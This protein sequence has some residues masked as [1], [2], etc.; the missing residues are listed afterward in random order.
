MSAAVARNLVTVQTLAEANRRAWTKASGVFA[1][2]INRRYTPFDGPQAHFDDAEEFEILYGGAKG[3]GKALC[4]ATPLPTPSGWTTMGQVRPGDRLFDEAGQPCRV[5][6]VTDVMRGHD[7]YRVTFSDGA[8]IIA[9]ADHEWLTWTLAERSA[10]VRRTDEFRAQRRTARPKRG[11]GIREFVA[12]IG[13]TK[14]SPT[15]RVRTTTEIARSLRSGGKLNALNHAAP[16]AGPLSLC[17]ADLPINPYLLGAW[18]GDGDSARG[19]LTIGEAD[20]PEMLPI[21][22]EAGADAVHSAKKTTQFRLAGLT[23]QLRALGVLNDKHIPTSYLRGGVTQRLALLQG[24][25]DTDG[26]VTRDGSIEVTWTKRV[27]V[28]GLAE[29]LASL[30]IKAR[31]RPGRA[32]IAGKDCGP[33]WR[34]HFS[35]ELP[36]AR[37]PRKLNAQRRAGLNRRTRFRY[38]TSVEPVPSVPVRCIRVDSPSRLFLAGPAM[39]PTHNSHALLYKPLKYIHRPTCKVLFLRV[40]F[41]SLQENMDR[42][43]RDFPKFG[44]KWN[45]VHR[46]WTFPSGARY[47]FGY[48]ETPKDV[49]RYAGREP[50]IIAYDQLEQLANEKVWTELLA[51]IRSPDPLILR[52]ALAS[53]NPGGPGE[54]W[55]IKRWVKLCGEDGSRIFT[56]PEEPEMTRR[57][58]PGRVTDNPIYANDKKYMAT[59]RSL[60]LRQRQQKLEGKWGVGSG[61]GLDEL[62]E[63]IHIVPTFNVPRHWFVWGAFDWGFGHPFSFGWF[64]QDEDGTVYLI[65]S[66]HGHR[67]LPWEQA[68]RIK[69]VAPE[70]ARARVHAGHDC[71]AVKRSMGENTPTIAETFRQYDILLTQANIDRVQGLNNMREYIKWQGPDGQTW[72]PRFFIMDTPNNRHVYDVLESMMTDPDRP[73][74]VLKRDADPDDG[75]GGD[76]P[77]DMARM[78]LA[79]RPAKTCR[80]DEDDVNV[81]SPEALAE[82]AADAR[83]LKRRVTRSKKRFKA[84]IDDD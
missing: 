3:P 46:R 37:L 64:C 14:G 24:I 33:K 52:Q 35:T 45:E 54:P 43:Q 19:Y 56:D 9:D 77:Y 83:T 62:N 55:L 42:A 13:A 84:E 27:L 28:D 20:Q 8:E 79:A 31:V 17:D 71:W 73:E 67:M 82:H 38:I 12:R 40:D 7:C 68:E 49:R 75:E 61:R 34:I 22:R 30:G 48:A 81:F 51:E 26:Y 63:R 6:S 65:D 70:R 50:S 74:D 53:A 66:M 57:F 78:G 32:S 58:I 44:A 18:L 10:A 80:Q 5:V 59:L 29:L 11:R 21:L 15:G 39:V 60:P 47:E 76:D 36:A 41:P 4:L 2:P 1:T 16:T 69:S 25:V 72:R 23:T